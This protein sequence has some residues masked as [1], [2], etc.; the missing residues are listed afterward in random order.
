MVSNGGSDK[1]RI[2]SDIRPVRVPQNRQKETAK[3]TVP[4]LE[5]EEII[6][7]NT[8]EPKSQQTYDDLDK[9]IES[10]IQSE[11][12]LTQ[13]ESKQKKPKL[14]K[15]RSKFSRTKIREFKPRIKK[16]SKKYIII[17]SILSALSISSFYAYNHYQSLSKDQKI[18]EQQKKKEAATIKTPNYST[19]LPENKTIEDL[20]GWTRVSPPDR[21]PVFAYLDSIDGKQINVSQQP[22]PDDFKD[23]TAAQIEVFANGYHADK[24]LQAGDTTFFLGT[25]AKGPQS[26]I[27]AKNNLLILIKS[28]VVINDDKWIDYINSLK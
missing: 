19:V 2:F 22:L 6:E 8:K 12:K 21:D 15:I 10:I 28:T 17:G 7:A 26:V 11:S 14:N 25:S 20:G 13:K 9:E 27:I 1:K 16:P 4:N 3:D 23:D 18:I 24:K 5:L